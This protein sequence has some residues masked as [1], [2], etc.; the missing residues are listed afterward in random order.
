MLFLLLCF[1]LFFLLE[2]KSWLSIEKEG[3]KI[4]PFGT[5][6][7]FDG[8]NSTSNPTTSN[9]KFTPELTSIAETEE[10]EKTPVGDTT[11]TMTAAA[12]DPQLL[13]HDIPPVG[14]LVDMQDRHGV[15]YQVSF[16]FFFLF[17]IFLSNP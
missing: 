1:S 12:I 9:H 6:T 2:S 10:E 13:I 17:E 4:A 16:L 3:D 7:G 14:A 8:G 11:T 5:R 15:W